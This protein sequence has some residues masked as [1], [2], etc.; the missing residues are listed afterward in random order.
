MI[1]R[2]DLERERDGLVALLNEDARNTER[3][4]NRLEALESERGVELHGALLLALTGLAFDAREAKDH[5]DSIRA[6]HESMRDAIGPSVGVRT[7]VLD[8]FVNVN[9]RL[10][11]PKLIELGM[12]DSASLDRP[13][14]ALT[15]L[16]DE[17]SFLRFLQGEMRRSRRFG[18]PVSVAS[19]DLDRFRRI[20]ERWG[21]P[22]GDRLIAEASM[23]I[24]NKIRDVD[25]AARPGEDE[26]AIVLPETG[27]NGA[28]LVAE[29]LRAAAAEHFERREVRGCPVPLT[30]SIGVATAPEDGNDAESILRRASEALYRAKSRG[31]DRVEAWCEERRRFVRF[32]LEPGRFEVEVI[33]SDRIRGSAADL[34]LAG[35]LFRSP[36]ALAVGEWIEVRLAERSEG[37]LATEHALRG[38]VVR[39]EAVPESEVERLEETVGFRDPYEIGVAFAAEDVGGEAELWELLA[40][41]QAPEPIS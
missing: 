6:H 17:T 26:F 34:S 23:V 2:E 11:Q 12:L 37:R 35:V 36:E 15:G 9:R 20:N 5:W 29:R 41:L 16:A 24:S 1:R 10:V 40:R 31:K 21:R 19:V 18:G 4:L 22:M 39:V 30:V 3:L 25:L 28:L 14:D 8:Y 32:E 38:E 13:S 7:A 33:G 27:R